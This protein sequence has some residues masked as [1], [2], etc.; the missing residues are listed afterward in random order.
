MPAGSAGWRVVLESAAFKN[1]PNAKADDRAHH[2][3]P[4]AEV[5]LTREAGDRQTDVAR[6]EAAERHEAPEQP[7]AAP[8]LDPLD[9]PVMLLPVSCGPR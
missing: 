6:G 4:D 7:D 9:A 8:F 5:D 2:C 3:G 1:E